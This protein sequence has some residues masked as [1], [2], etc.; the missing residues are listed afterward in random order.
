[1]KKRNKAIM[2]SEFQVNMCYNLQ[3]V[4]NKQTL[5]AKSD[6]IFFQAFS[7]R[8]FGLTLPA[9]RFT[10]NLAKKQSF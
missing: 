6:S 9:S 10:E 2:Y 3:S 1:M 4:C 5:C 7:A 8:Y